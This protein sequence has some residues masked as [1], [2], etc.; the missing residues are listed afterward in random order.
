MGKGTSA[1]GPWIPQRVVLANLIG[2]APR[3][4]DPFVAAPLTELMERLILGAGDS[5]PGRASP[6]K[7]AC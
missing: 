2:A 5:A 1:G 3:S 6:S 7:R 4:T